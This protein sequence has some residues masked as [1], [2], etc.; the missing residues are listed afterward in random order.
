MKKIL[1][2]ALLLLSGV[3]QA[4][5]I[6]LN[7]TL[8]SNGLTFPIVHGYQV[9]GGSFPV[10][11]TTARDAIDSSLR[12]IGM[13]VYD[14][15]NSKTWQLVGGITNSDWR[16]G[17]F[18]PSIDT[19]AA[20]T[21]TLGGTNATAIN[22][23]STL[24]DITI[25]A[26][27]F[28][29][30]AYAPTTPS[31]VG[32]DSY[33]I[34]SAGS[35]SNGS[36]TG[37][38]GGQLYMQAGNG[39]AGA[40]I[41]D[42]G[43]GAQAF[44][45]G[46]DCGS[47]GAGNCN[48]GHLSLYGGLGRGTGRGG[49]VIISGYSGSRIFI[50]DETIG[51]D[52]NFAGV[53]STTGNQVGSA[54]NDVAGRIVTFTTE[55]GGNA[56]SGVGKAGGI[57]LLQP[58]QSGSGNASFNGGVG[59]EL[60]LWG[61]RGGTAGS[62]TTAGVGGIVDLRGGAGGLVGS[63]SGANGGAVQITGGSSSG[64]GTTGGAVTIA[65]GT[66]SGTNGAITIGATGTSAVNIGAGSITTTISGT[67]AVPATVT[68]AASWS[69]LQTFT[70]HIAGGGS[71]PSIGSFANCGSGCTGSIAGTDSAFE[72]TLTTGTGAG[73]GTYAT[74]TFANAYASTPYCVSRL[75]GQTGAGATSAFFV[76]DRANSSASDLKLY[77]SN[78]P[79][80]S[81]TYKITV[82]CMQ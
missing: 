65:G 64:T 49:D 21:F 11:D 32:A 50:G 51:R 2:A 66:G 45:G 56:S 19:A 44:L 15:A 24:A 20:G 71:A 78:T 14:Q 18:E 28:Q 9:Q 29:M 74:I 57:L 38:I 41:R 12:Q 37:G 22:I 52:F 70:R 60:R 48:G 23:G 54:A 47:G 42:P 34:V 26:K 6:L 1:V 76:I 25:S 35:A 46:G 53:L 81:T 10:A 68:G 27:S 77:V 59:T 16:G 31:T 67:L 61:P 13:R 39:G 63:G 4:A 58:G 69:S 17:L 5:D 75:S 73:A 62:G 80:S 3:A 72:I 7:D 79:S 43:D 33:Y 36:A 40:G 55:A 82:L 30:I 8:A